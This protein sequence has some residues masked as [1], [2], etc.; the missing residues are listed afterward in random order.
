MMIK[1]NVWDSEK[2]G[3][4]ILTKDVVAKYKDWEIEEHKFM[5]MTTYYIAKDSF[6]N[7]RQINSD[8][9]PDNFH[10]LSIEEKIEI[11]KP[12]LDK[13]DKQLKYDGRKKKR[14]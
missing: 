1:I 9:E 13:T 6:Y 8:E 14:G 7:E 10:S 3:R 11:F 2:D 4:D 5:G 12:I